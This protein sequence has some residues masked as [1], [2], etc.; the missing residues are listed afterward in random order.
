M[1]STPKPQDKSSPAP[2]SDKRI[3][4]L[5]VA[6]E[7]SSDQH[8]AGLVSSFLR[9]C[10]NAY[11]FGM[12]G[13]RLRK[14]GMETIV[15]SETTASVMGFVELGGSIKRLFSA[16]RELLKKVDRE[17]PDIAILV[18]FPDFNLR[19]AKALHKRKIKVFYY[20][21]PQLW[22]W[23]PRR[24]KIIKKYVNKVATIFPFEETFYLNHGIDAQFVGHPFLDQPPLNIDRSNYLQSIGLDS[25]RPVVALLPGSRRS[26]VERLLVPLVDGFEL[27]KKRY[28]D[29]QAV[30]PV[31][32]ML[33]MEWVRGLLGDKNSVTLARGQ[34]REILHVADAAAIASGTVTIEA[35]LSGIPFMV[36]YKFASLTYIFARMLVRGIKHFAMANLVANT[37]VVEELLQGDVNAERIANELER[38]LGDSQYRIKMREGLKLVR[39]NLN[40]KQLE[41]ESSADRVAGLVFEVALEEV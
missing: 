18:D 41:G 6:G 19:L 34:A 36:I 35:A 8:S 24:A 10:P 13:S 7:A 28:P 1:V 5:L 4:M 15:D 29:L 30:V 12:G 9:M 16:Y 25:E 31:A 11:V 17:K 40:M 2:F 23:R 37:K 32:E 3:K 20:I 39:E 33:D 21:S 22:A 14:A 27:L 38:L 26:E